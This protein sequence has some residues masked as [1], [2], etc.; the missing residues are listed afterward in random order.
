ME[1]KSKPIKKYTEEEQF[2]R[3]QEDNAVIVGKKKEQNLLA[4][5]S[6]IIDDEAKQ[7]EERRK[8]WQKQIG[9]P[10]QIIV[11]DDYKHDDKMITH[12]FGFWKISEGVLVIQINKLGPD[13]ARQQVFTT[14]FIEKLV[15]CLKG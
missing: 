13:P 2:E 15:N 4:G 5:W 11:I 1:K 3:R 6:K 9:E 7:V 14:E 10:N 12:K 8:Q